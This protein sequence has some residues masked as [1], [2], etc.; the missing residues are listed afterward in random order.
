MVLFL[1]H[2]LRANEH[3]NV[4][5]QYRIV[6]AIDHPAWF[7]IAG[8]CAFVPPYVATALLTRGGATKLWKMIQPAK[9]D[10]KLSERTASP[11]KSVKV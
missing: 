1:P 2:A 4:A 7:N 9:R 8:M 6:Q 5:I 3:L 11:A 10:K